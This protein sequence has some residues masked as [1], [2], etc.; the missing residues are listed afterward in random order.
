[1]AQ[2]YNI[3]VNI[4][5][6]DKRIYCSKIHLFSFVC[7]V[8]HAL[9]FVGCLNT[10]HRT[11]SFTIEADW[12]LKF[13]IYTAP[14]PPD[15]FFGQR[16]LIPA[17]KKHQS[18]HRY[19]HV[20]IC[21]CRWP[22]YNQFLNWR[23]RPDFFLTPASVLICSPVLVPCSLTGSNLQIWDYRAKE[24]LELFL[25]CAVQFFWVQSLDARKNVSDSM[26]VIL[27]VEPRLQ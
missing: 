20:L 8:S 18:C 4:C 17:I 14:C 7:E 27:D 11:I 19:L 16:W 26:T 9:L 3:S 25:R 10:K 24:Y 23:C 21:V 5:V 6:F 15:F 13:S 12:R 1:M 22:N 2:L